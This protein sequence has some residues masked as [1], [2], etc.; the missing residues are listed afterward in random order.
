MSGKTG[1]GDSAI[2][3]AA[4]LTEH[5]YRSPIIAY[6]D[7]NVPYPPYPNDKTI[8]E[9]FEAQVSSTPHDEAIRMGD[10][11]LTYSELN[12]RAN[13]LAAHL[14]TLGVGPEQFVTLYMEHSIE[15]VC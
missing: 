4:P 5:E 11:S 10:R 1:N 6:N 13:Q 7:S 9:L 2:L 3:T 8:V 12:G 15:V 14:R